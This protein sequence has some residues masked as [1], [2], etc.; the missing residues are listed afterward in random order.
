VEDAAT[1]QGGAGAGTVGEEWKKQGCNSSSFTVGGKAGSGGT[2]SQ[3]V[4]EIPVPCTMQA[5][6]KI[7]FLSTSQKKNDVSSEFCNW[8]LGWHHNDNMTEYEGR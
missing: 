2:S 4:E 5:L 8:W 1:E 6:S 7:C 3:H